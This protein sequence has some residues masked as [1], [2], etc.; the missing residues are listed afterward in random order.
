MPFS[1]AMPLAVIANNTAF[2]SEI[3]HADSDP[4]FRNSVGF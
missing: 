3:A 1:A 2:F 4:M